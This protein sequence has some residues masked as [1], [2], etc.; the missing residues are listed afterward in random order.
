MT[1]TRGTYLNPLAQVLPGIED[2]ILEVHHD[3]MDGYGVRR[4]SSLSQAWS[5]ASQ[6]QATDV[7]PCP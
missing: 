3:P 7:W 6:A 5:Y 4:R 2:G 1:I